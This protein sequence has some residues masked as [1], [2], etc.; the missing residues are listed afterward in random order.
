MISNTF[1]EFFFF[2]NLVVIVKLLSRQRHRGTL[3]C[4]QLWVLTSL[5]SVCPTTAICI[6]SN[7]KAHIKFWIVFKGPVKSWQVLRATT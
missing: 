4:A 1:Y 3:H 5:S 7:I 6:S 2:E